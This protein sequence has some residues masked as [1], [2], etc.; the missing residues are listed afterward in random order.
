MP[1]NYPVY[2][3]PEHTAICGLSMGCA[4][5]MELGFKHPEL[6]DYVGCFSAGPS[7]R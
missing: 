1:A 2:G 6:F 7:P 5:S 4:Q 3:T